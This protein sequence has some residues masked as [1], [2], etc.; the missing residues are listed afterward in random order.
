MIAYD[1]LRIS[2]TQAAH[3]AKTFFDLSGKLSPLTGELDFNFKIDAPTGSYVLK[4]SRPDVDEDYVDFQQKIISQVAQ[5]NP[6]IRV[7]KII[8]DIRQQT[9]STWIDEI[10]QARKIRLLSWIDGR[11]W[12]GVNP[13]TEGLLYSLGLQAGLITQALTGFDHPKAHRI[14][15]WDIDQGDWTFTHTHL[16]EGRQAELIDLFQERFRALQPALAHLRKG[17]IHNDAN[18]NNIV[19]SKDLIH[20]EVLAIIDY[21]DAVFSS[22]V[23]DLAVAIA[24]AVMDKPDP[25]A[26]ALPIIRGYHASFQLLEAELEALYTLVS[27]RLVISVTKSAINKRQEPD[28]VYLLISE[29]SAW[30]LLEKWSAINPTLAY[31]HFRSACG[32]MAHPQQIAFQDWA[33]KN[34]VP[35]SVLFPTLNAL[36]TTPVDLSINSTWIGGK[37][38]FSDNDWMTAQLQRI[39]AEHPHSIIAGGYLETR[40]FY[41]TDAFKKQGLQGPEYRTIHLGVDFWLPAQ[42]PVCAPFDGRV[43]CITHND[44]D[45]DYGPTLILEHQF[46]GVPF[47]TLYGHLTLT[48]LTLLKPGQ[49]V[50]RGEL[51]AYI[52]AD[53]ENG[54]WSP[55]LHFQCMLDLLG[56]TDNFPGVAFPQQLEVWSSIC[57]DPNVFLQQKKLAP[58]LATLNPQHLLQERKKMLGRSL[59]LSYQAPLT[60]VRGDDV[61]L[62][63]HRGQK[64]LDTVNNVAHVGHEHPQ[65]VQA[66]QGQMALLNTNTRYL[67]P[68]IV[69]LAE[70]L[71]ATFPP[72]LSV[73]HFVNSG[74]E[75][76]ELALRMAKTVT[77]QRD[78]IAVEVGYHGNTNACIEVSSYKFDGKGGS[79]APEHTHIVPLPDAFRGKYRGENTGIAYA[80]HIQEQIAAI[81]AK[82]RNVAAFICESIISCGGQIELPEQYLALAY[83]AVRAAGGLCIA[84][85]V[86]VGCG[87]VGSHFWGFQA[88]GVIPD[89]VTIGKPL[90]NGHPLAAVVCTPTVADAFANGMEFFNTF[91]GNPVSCAIGKAVLEVVKK[92]NLQQHAWE[93]GN[94]LKNGLVELQKKY[95]IIGDV[96]GQGLFLGFELTDAQRSPLPEQ[97]AY[98]ANRMKVLGILM[99]TDGPDHNVLKIK[100]PMTFGFGHADELINRLATVFAEDFMDL[101]AH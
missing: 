80:A 20:P 31:C 43:F 18:D 41:T 7:P 64:Y 65:V 42:T 97:T 94:Y 82:G 37:H 76:N 69:E 40:P 22:L 75:A 70:A 21:G 101:A 74:S 28:N 99:S 72:E 98:L 56:N 73:V 4:V 55:H 23:N 59:S 11:L 15:H 44:F 3:L 33:Q 30:D 26:A 47:Y 25:L 38:Q 87:R 91:G 52:G 83:A 89:I 46:D 53:T 68:A 19:A 93:V 1:Q 63:D 50:Q 88:H 16:F 84:D 9:V 71:L 51:I 14:I 96:R 5:S 39:Q 81:Q 13:H 2:D 27:M 85:E 32:F 77:R 49:S 61:Y 90:G 36:D 60:I 45:K 6:K 86:Q 67:H 29:K 34:P 12:S 24:Y 79:G 10:G 54:N 62:I 95:P 57:P 48:S 66:G 100:P 78:M 92:E 8:P 35:L 58:A 17:V